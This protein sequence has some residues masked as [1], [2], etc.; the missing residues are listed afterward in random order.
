[1]RILDPAGRVVRTLLDRALPQGRHDA[2]WNGR[3]DAGRE[4]PAGI[5]LAR[6]EAGGRT[7]SRK[8]LVAR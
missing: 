3:D 1:M 8:I 5:Y 2:V 4:L 7:L 6:L